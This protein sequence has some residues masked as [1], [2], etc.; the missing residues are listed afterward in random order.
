MCH[1]A[2]WKDRNHSVAFNGY[3]TNESCH[4]RYLSQDAGLTTQEEVGDSVTVKARRVRLIFP[5][6]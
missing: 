3:A 1:A 6:S 4:Q 2:E 5:M